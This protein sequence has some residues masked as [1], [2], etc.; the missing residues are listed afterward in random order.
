MPAR[1]TN[2]TFDC[3]DALRLAT[4]WSEV[5]GRPLDAG[6]GPRYASIGGGDPQRAEPAW[7]FEAVP[8]TKVAKNRVH[9]D[10]VDPDPAAVRRLV[11]L[12]A[13]VVEEHQLGDGGHRW[14][15]MRDPEG[16]EFC[17]AAR[18]YTT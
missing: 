18:S 6:S 13:S 14:T 1:I 11:G 9:V 2:L 10:L 17:I 12:G 16:N 15:V 4:F 8:E 7:Y 3:V 5:I